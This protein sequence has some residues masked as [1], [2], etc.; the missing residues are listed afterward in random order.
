MTTRFIEIGKNL[1]FKKLPVL[2]YKIQNG[3]LIGGVRLIFYDKTW[4]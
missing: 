1:R 4:L 3:T 2:L